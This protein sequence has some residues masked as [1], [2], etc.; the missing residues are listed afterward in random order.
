LLS[1]TGFYSSFK[2]YFMFLML[3]YLMLHQHIRFKQFLFLGI[4]GV[5]GF[6]VFVIWQHVK[7]EYRSYLNSMGVNQN[8][9]DEFKR[10]TELVKNM[11][12][13]AYNDGVTR[14]IERTS[15]IDYF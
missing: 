9:S 14:L 7:P 8:S 1:F 2:E 10:L 3:G 5:I 6:N 12:T 15:Y 11:D 4:V 13:T